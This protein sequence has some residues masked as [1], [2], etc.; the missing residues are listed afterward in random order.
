MPTCDR[1]GCTTE[2]RWTEIVTDATK[3]NTSGDF[4][5]RPVHTVHLCWDHRP[6]A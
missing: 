6:N 1:T 4:W 5:N 3:A 2:A